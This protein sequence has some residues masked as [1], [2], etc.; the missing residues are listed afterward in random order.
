MELFVSHVLSGGFY[1][2]FHGVVCSARFERGF[3]FCFCIATVGRRIGRECYHFCLVSECSFHDFADAD[4][5]IGGG[6]GLTFLFGVGFLAWCRG[7][8]SG[9]F[10]SR[11]S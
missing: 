8:L 3:L 5:F 2:V 9:G 7:D 4:N 1:V 10:A 11:P 6:I